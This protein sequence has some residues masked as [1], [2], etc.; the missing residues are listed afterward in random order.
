M[1]GPGANGECGHRRPKVRC[2]RV[3]E[4]GVPVCGPRSARGPSA[5]IRPRSAVAAGRGEAAVRAARAERLREARGARAGGSGP[6]ARLGP[7]GGK[8]GLSGRRRV[9]CVSVPLSV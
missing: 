9:F 5:R 4:R 3:G 2:S 7:G 6:V 8:P 1:A